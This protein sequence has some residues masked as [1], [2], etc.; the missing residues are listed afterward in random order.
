MCTDIDNCVCVIGRSLMV[1]IG[2][3][4][5]IKRKNCWKTAVSQ[6]EFAIIAI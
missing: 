3:E 5:E 6:H 2:R 4:Y 1:L